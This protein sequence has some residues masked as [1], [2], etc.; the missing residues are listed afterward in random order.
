MNALMILVIAVVTVSSGSE[1][2]EP[3]N[4][5]SPSLG[6]ALLSIRAK[7]LMRV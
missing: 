5:G 1:M 3:F 2:R 4:G 7:P 6:K